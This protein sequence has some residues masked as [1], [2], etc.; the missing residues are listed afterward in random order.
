MRLGFVNVTWATASTT[1]SEAPDQRPAK[2]LW[3]RELLPAVHRR[4]ETCRRI[5]PA[6][7]RAPACCAA[8]DRVDVATRS[9]SSLVSVFDEI[10]GGLVA[11]CRQEYGSRLV[12][13]AVFDSVARASA[14]SD[15]D[16]DL[17]LVIDPL[18]DGRMARVAE[19]DVVERALGAALAEAALRGV[20]T[21]LSPVIK[22]PAEIRQGSP[23]LLDMTEDA[24][25]L[26]DIDGVLAGALNDLHQRLLAL[27]ARRIW[28][29]N[30]WYWDLKPDYQPGEVFEL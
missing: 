9:S 19:F 18:P 21:R 30:A 2:G 4:P 8:A 25:V 26:V 13:I 15:S 11:S 3:T 27:G 1:D 6:D 16:I 12:S 17:L 20:T 29:G 22:T 10:L 14:R 28:R 24:R 5:E 23:L 7:E